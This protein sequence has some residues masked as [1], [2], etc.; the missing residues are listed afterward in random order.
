MKSVACHGPITVKYS[1][2]NNSNNNI[3]P[4][5]FQLDFCTFLYCIA[6]FFYSL[7]IEYRGQKNNNLLYYYFILIIYFILLFI[8]SL[9]FYYFFIFYYYYLLLTVLFI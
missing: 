3:A 8:I 2:N 1:N 6:S 7:G 4:G 5:S 9:L